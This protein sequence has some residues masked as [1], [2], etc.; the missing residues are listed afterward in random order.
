MGACEEVHERW[1]HVR[2]YMRVHERC[3]CEE[4]YEGT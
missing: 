3:A 4:V 2:R 1:V